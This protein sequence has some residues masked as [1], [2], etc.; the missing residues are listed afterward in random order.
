MM[1]Q[2]KFLNYNNVP[3]WWG[4]LI[5]RVTMHVQGQGICE[6]SLNLPLNLN[7]SLKLLQK[8][9]SINIYFLN[10]DKFFCLLLVASGLHCSTRGLHCGM[11]ASLQLW[12]QGFLSLVAARGVQRVW[13][14]QFSARGIFAEAHEL[15]SC[16]MRA[17]L[18]RGMWDLSSLTRD[19]THIPYI[20]RRILYHWTTRGVPRPNFKTL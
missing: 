9:N 13:A 10:E 11:R 12:Y 2:Y 16:R 8:I 20:G 3:P 17:Q 1:D 15:S 6:K 19:R 18:P 14:L 4:I 5:M 7:V